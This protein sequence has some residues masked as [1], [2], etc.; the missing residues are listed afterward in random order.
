MSSCFEVRKRFKKRNFPKRLPQLTPSGDYTDP[1]FLSFG[2]KFYEKI[3][4]SAEICFQQPQLALKDMET[5]TDLPSLTPTFKSN[6]T[7]QKFLL[8]TSKNKERNT[9]FKQLTP[10]TFFPEFNL[11]KSTKLR[12]KSS[13]HLKRSLLRNQQGPDYSPLRRSPV[14]KK[15]LRSAMFQNQ[16][17]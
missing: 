11:N 10:V 13:G 14:S 1:D 7:S 15:I 6:Y 2:S 16:F 5:N 4:T 9:S 3:D 12:K 8:K 17:N